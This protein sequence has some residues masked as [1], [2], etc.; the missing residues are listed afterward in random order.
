[1][2][3][4]VGTVDLHVTSTSV[5]RLRDKQQWG[6]REGASIAL[7]GHWLNACE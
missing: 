6:P 3:G 7:F 5:Y 4:P 1:M 2:I